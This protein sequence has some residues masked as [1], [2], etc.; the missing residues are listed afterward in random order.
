MAKGEGTLG[1]IKRGTMGRTL[2]CCDAALLSHD[3]ERPE[4]C[5]LAGMRRVADDI[6]RI[7]MVLAEDEAVA[8][9]AVLSQ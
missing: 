6:K 7:R 8:A 4:L 3:I 1:R 2:T 9:D 5:V